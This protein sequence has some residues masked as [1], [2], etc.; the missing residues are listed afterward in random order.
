MLLLLRK[1]SLIKTTNRKIDRGNCSEMQSFEA[2]HDIKLRFLN[3]FL[4][5]GLSALLLSI[6][7][8]YP[9][10]WYFSLIA[11]VPF[12]GYLK[13]ADISGAVVTGT[14]LAC[15]Y[16]IVTFAS[17]MFFFPLVFLYKLSLLI[18]VFSIFGAGIVWLK[19][20]FG[21]NP[22]FIGALWLPLE[23]VL[24]HLAGLGNIF[25]F[26]DV[27][28]SFVIRFASVF[29]CLMVAFAI[30]LINS[31]ILI[32]FECL[33]RI[34]FSSAKF[35][36]AREKRYYSYATNSPSVKNRYNVRSPRAPPRFCNI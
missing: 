22:I 28:S 27:N 19:R 17:D 5:A 2:C 4:F 18:I 25:A 15:C 8:I 31:L 11:L 32:F 16:G 29:G 21:F 13:K 26:T 3:R 14:I 34:A 12:L 10:Y 35:K 23:F 24:I 36:F 9:V 1:A 7:H 33:G 6:A 20:I 30:V